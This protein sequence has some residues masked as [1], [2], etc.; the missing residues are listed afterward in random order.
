M[1][2]TASSPLVLSNLGPCLKFTDEVAHFQQKKPIAL[3][4]QENLEA[5]GILEFQ[6]SNA[7]LSCLAVSLA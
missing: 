2:T 4:L 1:I 3:D 6:G 7:G 5:L